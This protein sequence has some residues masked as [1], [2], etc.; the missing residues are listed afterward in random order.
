M[1]ELRLAAYVISGITS[2][3]LKSWLIHV[4]ILHVSIFI[5]AIY[6]IGLI[7]PGCVCVLFWFNI[8]FNNLSVISQQSLVA[9]GS[10]QC[11]LTVVSSSRHF[12]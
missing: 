4:S 9:T 1:Y 12:T 3:N 11:C 6:L 7:K 2:L 5:K 10:S 8:I